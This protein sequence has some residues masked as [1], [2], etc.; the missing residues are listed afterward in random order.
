[1]SSSEAEARLLQEIRWLKLPEPESEYH[2]ARPRKWRFDLCWPER[3]LAV[4][5]EGGGFIGGRHSQGVGL[6]KDTEKY[7]EAL[8]LGWRVLRVTPAQITSGEAIHWVT[9]GLRLANP[10]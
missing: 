3:H 7:N 1:M 10:A 2:F 8:L 6:A 5:V 9:R 4:E